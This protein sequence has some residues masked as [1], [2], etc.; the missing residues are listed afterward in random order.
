MITLKN[1]REIKAQIEALQAK[2][3]GMEG[4]DQLQQEIQFENRLQGLLAEF[5]KT[6]KDVL[7][8]LDKD[9]SLRGRQVSA[10]VAVETESAT[11][12]TRRTKRYSNP[13]T[14][15][16]IETKGGNHNTLKEWK[17]SWGNDTVESWGEF[18]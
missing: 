1:Y 18:I 9:G 15:E 8:I 3:Q 11:K 13:N 17:A 2:L 10:P 5:G 14:G 6:E 7:D 12:R 4:S 16:V